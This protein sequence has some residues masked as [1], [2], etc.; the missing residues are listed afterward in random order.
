[1]KS[2]QAHKHKYATCS[3]YSLYMLDIDQPTD[4]DFLLLFLSH[5]SSTKSASSQRKEMFSEYIVHSMG[6]VKLRIDSSSSR[7]FADNS[8]ENLSF[9]T[10]F[11][12]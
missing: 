5:N 2:K 6:T 10:A 4:S 7:F 1:M 12:D 9:M 8:M 11:C 3:I